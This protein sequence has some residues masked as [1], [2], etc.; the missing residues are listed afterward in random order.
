MSK[1]QKIWLWISVAMF[2]I[3]EILWSP[4]SNFYYELLQSSSTSYVKPFRYSFLQNSDNLNY[5][6]FF[7]FLQLIGLLGTLVVAI[8][9]KNNKNAIWIYISTI[10]LIALLLLVAFELYFAMTFS[11]DIM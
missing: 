4:V 1:S 3:P 11:I 2:A 8:K 7:V 5:L 9:N 6:K 10:L